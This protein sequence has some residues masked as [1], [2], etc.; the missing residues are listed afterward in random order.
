[1]GRMRVSALVAMVGMVGVVLG[2]EPMPGEVGAH[3]HSFEV[4]LGWHMG[5]SG[6]GIFVN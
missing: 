2:G 3:G 5:T 6:H 1:M 4:G